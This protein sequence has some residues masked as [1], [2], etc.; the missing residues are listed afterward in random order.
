MAGS[1]KMAALYSSI[2]ELEVMAPEREPFLPLKEATDDPIT[3]DSPEPFQRYF[4][5]RK[6]VFNLALL[7]LVLISLYTFATAWVLHTQDTGLLPSSCKCG[8]ATSGIAA[9]AC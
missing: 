4:S 9:V 6:T 1:D 2:V 8:V 7:Q 3:A 5:I